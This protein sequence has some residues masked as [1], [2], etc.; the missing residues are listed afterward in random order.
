MNK[1]IDMML[2][3][4]QNAYAFE[5][6]KGQLVYVPLDKLHPHPDNPRKEIGDV[7]ELADSIKS[8][9][10]MQNLT[11]V[12]AKDGYTVIIGHRRCAAAKL[13]GLKEVPCVIVEMSDREQVATML[14]E[15][16]QRVDL[17]PYEQAAGFQMMMDFGESVD[18]I[19]EKTG[20]SKRTVKR[21]LKMAELD[22][23]VLRSV[24]DRQIS[25]D[26]FDKL[27]QVEDIKKRNE[28]LKDIGTN[29]FNHRVQAQIISQKT[30]KNIP[31]VTETIK[32]VHGNK[33]AYSE[34]YSGNYIKIFETKISEY[35]GDYE[36]PDDRKGEKIFYFWDES[37]NVFKLYVRAPK[38]APVKRSAK[39]IESEKR[40]AQAHDTLNALSSEAYK[41]RQEFIKAYRFT[42]EHFE[43]MFDGAILA[44]LSEQ[45]S[46]NS[47]VNKTEIYRD[48]CGSEFDE[49]NYNAQHRLDAIM[50]AYKKNSKRAA[51]GIIYC[52]FGDTAGQV[53]HTTFKREYPKH[54]RNRQLELLYQWLCSIG[55]EMSDIE[56]SLMDG[57]HPIF[58]EDTN[59]RNK[60]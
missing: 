17:T 10:V 15:N 55:Y 31:M 49:N 58:K 8:K 29:N 9:G 23:D 1:E 36:L 11:V 13:A 20:F 51:V 33:L 35:E 30:K 4:L 46:Y 52:S 24:S 32:R 59:D 40:I 53:F 39:E 16:M 2:E 37:Y 14:L 27:A 60:S 38:A 22:R 19:S 25:L 45:Y 42:K 6:E 41:L 28:I 26:D 5:E 3:E 50:T 56:K 54:Q 34:T 7:T 47:H 48:I 12:P 44:L 18:S 21:R 57:T 43:K